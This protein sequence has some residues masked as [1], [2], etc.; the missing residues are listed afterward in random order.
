LQAT[1]DSW[2]TLRSTDA[3]A[4][5]IRLG[6]FSEMQL[7]DYMYFNGEVLKISRL[8]R[9]PD[10]DMNYYANRG[11]RRD[12]F[13]TSPAAHGLDDV[14]YVVEAKPPG[15]K[16]VANGLPVFTLNYSNDDDSARKLGSDSYLI[17]TA[18]EKGSYLV[19]VS[20]TRGWS[21][22]RFAYRLIVRAPKPDFEVKLLTAAEINVPS[23]SGLQFALETSRSD[24]WDG[25]VK[26]D[27]KNVPE[28][29]FVST[30]IV[31]EAGH[32]EAS[33]CMYALPET[34]MGPYDFS[35]VQV[36]CTGTINGKEVTKPVNGFPKVSV[37][38]APKKIL[39][40]EPDVAGKPE[41]D[42]KTPPQKPYEITIA[43][44]TTV[45]AWL[46]VDR[47]GDD[48]I[49]P[50]DV[51]NLPHGVIVDN[52]G[53]NGV[54]IRAGENIREIFLSCAGFVPDQDRL[55]HVIIGSART[56]AVKEAGATAGFPVL[57]KVRRPQ[58]V[59]AK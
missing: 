47:K 19:R 26:V 36:T 5:G 37:V 42:G 12:Y 35:K 10:A 18:P 38:A 24:G 57:L 15:A 52:I 41:G 8:A 11:K 58:P 7:D 48:A 56:D 14:C 39:F 44:G 43:P 59:V 32:L 23:A 2:L 28:G 49:I 21:G 17:F 9:G 54:Q 6:Q 16:L 1:R 31:T 50:C 25:D 55:C 3:N 29:F 27:I 45:S 46:R 33:G 22:D 53:L 13:F 4:P 20:D 30:P 51:E 34:K 40:M